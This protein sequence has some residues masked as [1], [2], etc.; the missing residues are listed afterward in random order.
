MNVKIIIL[1][2]I[3]GVSLLISTTAFSQPS[4][5]L[6]GATLNNGI[7][8]QN[9]NKIIF[10]FNR[11]MASSDTEISITLPT[12]VNTFTV[13]KD[14][15]ICPIDGATD[16]TGSF[17]IVTT[18]NPGSLTILD[19]GET[20]GTSLFVVTIEAAAA[21]PIGSCD[22]QVNPTTTTNADIQYARA[23]PNINLNPPASVLSGE[24]GIA[25]NTSGTGPTYSGSI[26]PSIASYSWSQISGPTVVLS[27]TTAAS[28]TF[29]ATSV[30]VDTDVV[31]QVVVT[32]DADAIPSSGDEL[33]ATKTVTIEELAKQNPIDAVLLMD[34]SGSMGWH[35]SGSANDLYGGCCSRLASAKIAAKYFV[36]RLGTFASDSR[37]GVAIFPAKPAPASNPDDYGNRYTPPTDLAVFSG[38]TGIKND[39]GG[40]DIVCSDCLTIPGSPGSTTGI[41]V[42]WNSTPTQY[43]L[44]AARTMLTT[45]SGSSG[46]SR[47]ILLLSDGAWN[48]GSDP[49]DSSYLSGFVSDGIQIY[50]IGMGTGADNVNHTSLQNISVNTNIGTGGNPFGFTTYNFGEPATEP[51][52]FPFLEKIMG[53]MNSLDFSVDPPDTIYPG[54]AKNHRVLVTSL[55]SL[56]SFTISWE[57]SKKEL[58]YFHVIT[59]DGTRLKPTT[60]ENGYSNITVE[61]ELLDNPKNVG[62]WIIEVKNPSEKT[63]VV[64]NYSVMTKSDLNMKIL[65]DKEKYNTADK[66]LIEA[67]LI[68]K[69]RRLK[70]AQVI[71][72]VTRPE[73]AIGNWHNKNIVSMDRIKEVPDIISEEPLSLLDK[74]NYVLLQVDH[75]KLPPIITDTDIIFNDE[76]IDGDKYPDDGIYTGLYKNF[77]TPGIFKFH[78]IATGK[79]ENG[80]EFRRENEVQ[81]YVDMVPDSKLTIKTGEMTS[82]PRSAL[83]TINVTPMDRFKNLLGP[84][85]DKEIIVK[86]SE[87]RPMEGDLGDLLNGTYQRKFIVKSIDQNP[88]ITIIVRGEKIYEKPF[89]ELNKEN[90]EFNRLIKQ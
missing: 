56:L 54:P 45:A 42:N 4:I 50:T 24:T 17:I 39:I 89:N 37:L 47:V 34:T 82:L 31:L 16:C 68:E 8:I 49:A 64:Y 6:T 7:S 79:T 9:S 90:D 46:R 27:S 62:T 20:A 11:T 36:D 10:A 13:T 30:T 44:D 59:P 32:D 15:A 86:S 25:L 52:L 19:F 69:N 29:D 80:E 83:M 33:V 57:S 22:W 75:T 85:Y 87:G 51:N 18:S 63:P 23:I 40:E 41:P 14:G 2:C 73:S 1:F 55:D 5:S 12:G 72:R 81:K 3:L 77:V 26:S 60:I 70:G 88:L 67:R 65:L 61:G 28:P 53:H 78:I 38:F 71:A 66:M 58:L 74:K 48:L 21:V 35:R 84:G 43:G 76:G